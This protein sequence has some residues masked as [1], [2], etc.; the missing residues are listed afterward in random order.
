MN[1]FIPIP[2][3]F[4]LFLSMGVLASQNRLSILFIIL[5]HCFYSFVSIFL[6]TIS[7]TLMFTGFTSWTIA[8]CAAL[9]EM[10]VKP[11]FCPPASTATYFH[12][13]DY[14]GGELS[15]QC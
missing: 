15:C 9:I 14:T 8:R 6:P 7:I 2:S 3:Q 11:W 13:F 5:S 12:E 1:K 10:K 4:S